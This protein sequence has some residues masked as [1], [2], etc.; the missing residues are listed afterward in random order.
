MGSECSVEMV[1]CKS[2]AGEDITAS[3][4]LLRLSLCVDGA[5]LNES[6]LFTSSASLYR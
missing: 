2:L 5:V 4:M 1:Y 3:S 6:S